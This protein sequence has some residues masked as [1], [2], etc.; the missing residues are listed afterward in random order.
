MPPKNIAAVRQFNPSICDWNG[1]RW[2]A[3]RVEHKDATSSIALGQL[4]ENQITKATVLEIPGFVED[5][6]LLTIGD[7]L[8][9]QVARIARRK[10]GNN[11]TV[12]QEFYTITPKGI[13]KGPTIPGWFCNGIKGM[14]TK[15]WTAFDFENRLHAQHRPG[16]DLVAGDDHTPAHQHQRPAFLYPFGTLS[17]RTPALKIGNEYIALCGGRTPHPTGCSR[18]YM[19][20]WSFQAAPP[21]GITRISAR[22]IL[23]AGEQDEIT[24]HPKNPGYRDRCLFPAGIVQEGDKLIV[25]AGIN[26]SWMCLLTIPLGALDLVPLDHHFEVRQVCAPDAI[27]PRGHAVVRVQHQPLSEDGA[28]FWPGEYFITTI[29][30]AD[31]IRQS[32]EIIQQKEAA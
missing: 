32:I 10:G 6:R 2:I 7:S 20:A 17:G 25:S 12:I 5:P 31:A 16:E 11:V 18:Y 27:P 30:R 4:K 8:M 23:W 19:S 14:I 29:A 15:N 21:F 22:P 3:W 26:D 1:T 28:I 24:P 9:L 13:I